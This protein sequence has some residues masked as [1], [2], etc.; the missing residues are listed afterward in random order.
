MSHKPLK[1]VHKTMLEQADLCGRLPYLRYHFAGKGVTK[2]GLP[3]PQTAIGSAMHK[4]CEKLF[5]STSLEL[6]QVEAMNEWN[7]ETKDAWRY[8]PDHVSSQMRSEY[9]GIISQVLDLWHR[10]RYPAILAEYTVLNAEQKAF[11]NLT[12][13]LT[14][15]AKPDAVLISKFDGRLFDHS[16]KTKKSYNRIKHPKALIDI[17]GLTETT[18]IAMNYAGGKLAN[19]GGVLM[20]YL[21]VGEMSKTEPVI[22]HPALRG[23][24][25]ASPGGLT[26]G[27][28]YAWRWEYP[29]PDYDPATLWSKK[30]TKTKSL[31]KKD[32]WE[33]CTYLDHPGGASGWLDDL[34]ACRM[35]PLGLNPLNE[36]VYAPDPYVR[37]EGQ[38]ESF[39]TQ[40][41]AWARDWNQSLARLDAGENIDAIPAFRQHREACLK[42]GEDYRCE[43][44]DIC[45]KGA[46]RDPSM[47][48]YVP[49]KSSLDKER[50]QNANVPATGESK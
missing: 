12:D 14:L 34:L 29:N 26:G 44:W 32:G 2:D 22:W 45:W 35:Q 27:Y 20:E 16:L 17:E 28:E 39:L 46:G 18:A 47:A 49:R 4:G 11:V 8:T 7:Y 9:L 41:V 5:S 6:A 33:R 15:M 25:R 42:F 36:I 1:F 23:W 40:T 3:N 30:N 37:A 21:V 13:D 19:V 43:M 50:E 10:V 38:I 48:G 24:R 31:S